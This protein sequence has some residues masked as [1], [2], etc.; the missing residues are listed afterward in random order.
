MM[1]H[2]YFV[3]FYRYAM[4]VLQHFWGAIGLING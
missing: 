2:G 1:S 3:H 4:F